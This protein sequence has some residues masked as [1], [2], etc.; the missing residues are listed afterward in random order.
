MSETE[1]AP[2]IHPTALIEDDVRIGARTAI[3]DHVHVRHGASIGRDCIVGEKTYVAYD[4]R[5]GDLCKINASVYVCAGVTIEA[6][7][8]ISA[9]V[10]FT[11]DRSP[12]ATD[13]EITRLLDSAPNEDTL[14]TVV[15]RGAT[16]GAN[17]TIGPGLELGVHCMVGMGAVVTRDVPPHG[18][19]VGNPARLVGLVSRRGAPVWRAGPDGALPPDGTVLECD[20]DGRLRVS[21]GTVRWEP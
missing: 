17:A 15:R 18:L 19:V 4:V 13:P 3:W 11:N 9:H 5:I 20:G 8:M 6:G 12:R 7:C 2:R 14:S 1:D 21:D 10:V 16:I